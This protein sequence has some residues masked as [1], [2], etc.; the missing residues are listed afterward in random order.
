MIDRSLNILTLIILLLVVLVVLSNLHFAWEQ[1]E[2]WEQEWLPKN[3]VEQTHTPE[4]LIAAL[5]NAR[6]QREIADSLKLEDS[7]K[8]M[9]WSSGKVN[10][11][12]NPSEIQDIAA[13]SLLSLLLLI[14]PLSVNYIRH[15][16]FKLWNK[17]A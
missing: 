6:A 2:L 9:Y 11:R 17:G 13:Y 8:A 1:S 7:L 4:E 3:N 10:K 14:I 15:G 12:F 16:K 5:R